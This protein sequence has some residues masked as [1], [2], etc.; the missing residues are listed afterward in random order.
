LRDVT[1]SASN[2]G[3]FVDRSAYLCAVESI[4]KDS[5]TGLNILN[6]NVYFNKMILTGNHFAVRGKTNE[7]WLE[8]GLKFIDNEID[9]IE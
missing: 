3:I 2:T 7:Q 1:V 5:K 6:P 9:M 8:N 4:I